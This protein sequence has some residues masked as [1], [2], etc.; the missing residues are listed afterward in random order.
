M[1]ICGD[2]VRSFSSE[3]FRITKSGS[4]RADDVQ[5]SLLQ[6]DLV[7]TDLGIRKDSATAAEVERIVA[8][9]TSLN[10]SKTATSGHIL[11]KQNI[12]D[13]T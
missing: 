4:I 7:K 10:S 13:G 8:Q 1:D 5:A 3:A 2:Q 6:C 9:V 11:D 12:L